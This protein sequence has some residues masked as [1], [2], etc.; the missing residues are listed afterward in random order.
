[1]KKVCIQC[2]KEFKTYKK[3]K[4]YCSRNCYFLSQNPIGEKF[5]VVCDKSFDHAGQRSRKYCSRKCMGIANSGKNNYFWE[6]G[7]HHTHRGYIRITVAP[8][9]RKYEHVLIMEEHIGRNLKN[10]ENVHHINGVKH[11]NRLENLKLLT[12]KEH[13][14]LHATNKYS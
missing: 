7:R 2:G 4:K 5:C 8:Y 1:M 13:T 6:G 3:N 12:I 11:D 10:N 9:K 14:R